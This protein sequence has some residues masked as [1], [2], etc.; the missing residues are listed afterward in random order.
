MSDQPGQHDPVQPGP[1]S[2]PQDPNNPVQPG[3]FSQPQDP[4]GQPG[5][6]DK[7]Y[8]QPGQPTGPYSQPG[9]YGQ[10]PY[11]QQQPSPYDQQPPSPYGSQYG[12]SQSGGSPYSQPGYYAAPQSKPLSLASLILGI[13][14]VVGFGFFI[15]P[16]IAAIVTGHL[17]LKREM[18]R[19]K[20]FA[21]AGLVLGYLALL[22]GV[23][24]WILV[25]VLALNSA[26]SGYYRQ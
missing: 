2:K 10:S 26:N 21:I 1:F 13:A 11:G 16:Q 7:P 9:P 8:G 23:I 15:L 17:A 14:S 4:S 22:F 18:P 24:F 5:P 12:G 20:G 25:T 3:P 19:G 6:Y